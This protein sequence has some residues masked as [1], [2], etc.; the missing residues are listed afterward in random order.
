[1]S[2]PVPLRAAIALGLCLAACSTPVW[3]REGASLAD[4][5]RDR[6]ECMET[7]GSSS[8]VMNLQKKLFLDRCLR[9]RGWALEGEQTPEAA[10]PTLSVPE[11]AP[12]LEPLTFDQCF[13]RCRELTDR[14]KAECFDTC[15]AA[16]PR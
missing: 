12:E 16:Q 5:E 9:E 13:D 10:P 2:K 14:T 1:M 3:V 15:L 4:L 8:R 7:F 11:A 6:A